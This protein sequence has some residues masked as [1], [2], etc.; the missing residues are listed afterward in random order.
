MSFLDFLPI[1]SNNN[2]IHSY[3]VKTT[4]L[5][6]LED[7]FP[8]GAKV[9]EFSNLADKSSFSYSQFESLLGGILINLN[10]DRN[11]IEREVYTKID[12]LQ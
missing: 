12:W 4:K 5:T 9:N 11:L 2:L 7:Y 3:S 8:R 10:L 6:S 1:G